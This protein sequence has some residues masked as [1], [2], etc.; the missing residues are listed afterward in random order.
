MPRPEHFDDMLYVAARLADGFDFVRVDLYNICGR[1]YFNEMT[2]TP[3]GASMKFIPPAWDV[4][5]GRKWR[6]D[7]LTCRAE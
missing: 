7:A 1:I 6:V 3:T 5:L 4:T 2:F